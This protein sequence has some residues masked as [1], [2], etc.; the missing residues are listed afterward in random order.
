MKTLTTLLILLLATTA[1]AQAPAFVEYQWSQPTMTQGN[2]ALNIPPIPTPAGSLDKYEVWR[3][4]PSDT[5]FVGF[6][7]AVS[8]YTTD[9]QY[10]VAVDWNVPT[11]I[12]V[13]ALDVQGRAGPWSLWADV[14]TVEPG[15][16]GQTAKPEPVRVY[17][18]S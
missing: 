5:T 12:R 9:I 8:P 17:F 18:G 3:A 6:T 1:L 13:R 4:T 7:P 14:L 10:A 11:T 2:P 15:A 16:P